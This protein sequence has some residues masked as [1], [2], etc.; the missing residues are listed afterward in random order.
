MKIILACCPSWSVSYPPYNISLL[1]SILKQKGYTVKNFDFNIEA[2]N[3]LKKEEIDYWVGQN[4][5]FWEEKVFDNIILPKIEKLMDSW[6]SSILNYDPQYIGFTVYHTNWKC[7]QHLIKKIKEKNNNIK[8]LLGGPHCFASKKDFTFNSIS[9]YVCYGEGEDNIINIIEKIPSTSNRIDINKLPFPDYEDYD[10]VNYTAQHGVS[11]EASRGCVAKCSFCMETHFWKYQYKKADVLI[12]EIKEYKYKYNIKKFRFNDSLINGHIKEF[13]KFIELLIKENLNIQ[14]EAYARI[15]GKMDLE[16][17]RKIK[18]SGVT[19]LSYGIESGSQKVLNDMRKEITIKEI[20]QNLKDGYIAKIYCHV[21]WIVG[22]P[23]ETCYDNL[24]SL[25]FLFNN[26]NY[27]NDISPGMTCGIG[28]KSDLLKRGDRYKIM[29]ETPWDN[30]VTEGFKN[31]IIHRF[32]RLKCLHIWLQLIKIHNGQIDDDTLRSYYDI[33]FLDKKISD[34]IKYTEVVDFSC[35]HTKEFPSTL[36]SEY[37]SFFYAI[38]K[39]F[40]F[41]SIHLIFD[42]EKDILKYG[43]TLVKEYNSECWFKIKDDKWTFLLKHQLDTVKPFKETI[44]LSGNF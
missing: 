23:T 2:Y 27:I 28:V 1:K 30:F 39:V 34:N 31:T 8:I 15:N 18:L 24:L 19:Y 5:F 11:L 7:T 3:H 40:G 17:M 32:I 10:F 42:K 37:I 41:F 33:K 9:D 13:Y 38:Y 43:K 14:W 6:V 12:N 36:Y 29:N 35:L 22:F 44:T 4:F 26:R 25:L 21:N 16:F 20:E